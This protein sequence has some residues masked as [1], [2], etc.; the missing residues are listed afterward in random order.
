MK[1]FLEKHTEKITG[2][3][4]CF[5]RL[6]FKGYLPLTWPQRLESLISRNGR[7]IKEFK[8]FVSSSS[9]QL[10][11]HAKALAEKN[12]RVYRYLQGRASPASGSRAGT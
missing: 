1:E 2:T 12:G 11:K 5:D 10:V 7:K 8:D 4:S 3:I 6:I 9:D